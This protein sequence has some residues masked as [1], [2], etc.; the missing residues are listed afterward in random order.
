MVSCN[1]TRSTEPVSNRALSFRAI[2]RSSCDPSE[3]RAG[4]NGRFCT[5]CVTSVTFHFRFRSSTIA[6]PNSFGHG[7][8]ITNDSSRPSA[9]I[10]WPRDGICCLPERL[11]LVSVVPQPFHIKFGAH[12]ISVR[13]SIHPVFQIQSQ[14]LAVV[15]RRCGL[16]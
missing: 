1:L 13:A 2:A 12:G 10:I 15:P 3:F 7:S 9:R 8:P 4:T 16:G 11:D 14:N 5:L 6:S